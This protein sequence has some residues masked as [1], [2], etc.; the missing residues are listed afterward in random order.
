LVINPKINSNYN[1]SY[2][3]N[4]KRIRLKLIL[5]SKTYY[6]LTI[7]VT[8]NC[9]RIFVRVLFSTIESPSVSHVTGVYADDFGDGGEGN[10]GN[11]RLDTDDVPSPGADLTQSYPGSCVFM[12]MEI[13]SDILGATLSE[14]NL[15]TNYASEHDLSITSV[16]N[17]GVSITMG[18]GSTVSSDF[19][20]FDNELSENFMVTH[21]G[22][23]DLIPTLLNNSPIM[24]FI[25]N[26]A[27]NAHEI[28]IYAYSI[29]SEGTPVYQ[30]IDS[31]DGSY[32]NTS[33]GDAIVHPVGLSL[34]P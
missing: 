1:H 3:K 23:D 15:I 4:K 28:T 25:I 32:K 9:V 16:E 30:Y 10:P 33:P 2:Y 5:F 24:A 17:N 31:T 20:N 11:Y 21:L 6:F 7:G 34:Y 19:S 29:N 13:A 26:G 18:N 22:Q 14:D 12:N 8:E 27:G